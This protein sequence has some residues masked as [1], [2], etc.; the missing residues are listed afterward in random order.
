M[1]QI[2]VSSKH[3]WH[4]G[5]QCRS[6]S[7]GSLWAVSSGSALFVK[8]F[9]LVCRGEE[10]NGLTCLWLAPLLSSLIALR[11]LGPQV[12]WRLIQRLVSEVCWLWKSTWST[13]CFVLRWHWFVLCRPRFV[14]VTQWYL[15]Y[16]FDSVWRTITTIIQRKC[17]RQTIFSH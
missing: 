8:A 15:L 9:V 1:L 13:S 2:W 12:K 7:D 6:W 5:K 10:M 11:Q 4:T 17:F 16:Y 3:E 14:I